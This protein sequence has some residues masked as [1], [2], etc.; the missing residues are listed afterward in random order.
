MNA[1][2]RGSVRDPAVSGMFYPSDPDTLAADIRSMLDA[3]EP[4]EVPGEPVAF[5]VPHA[6]IV[7]S[8]PVAAYSYRHLAPGSFPRAV[9]VGSSHRYR[10]KSVSLYPEGTWSIPTGEFPVDTEFVRELRSRLSDEPEGPRPHFEEHCLEVQL[11]F[12][13]ETIGCVPIVPMLVGT[14]LL[15]FCRRLGSAL[16]DTI[17]EGHPAVL[18]ASTDLSHYHNQQ[19]A[20]V[21]D[22]AAI[23]A[24]L[25]LSTESLCREVST[26]ACELCGPAAVATVMSAATELGANRAT[27]LRYAT[28]GDVTGDFNQ[29][30]GYTAIAF[31]RED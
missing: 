23:D 24:M 28:S 6:G 20:E 25:S 8:G 18:L 17:R 1:R 22:R 10:I 21:L 2:D 9:L 4:V 11:P 12:L 27:L 5:I 29:V 26:G 31:S 16:A 30:V 3:V 7:Y 13:V 19:Q 14:L 15:G